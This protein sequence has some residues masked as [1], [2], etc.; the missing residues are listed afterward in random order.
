MTLRN[1]YQANLDYAFLLTR[2]GESTI[3]YDFTGINVDE[4]EPVPVFASSETHVLLAGCRQRV[5]P[6]MVGEGAFAHVYSYTEPEYDESSRSNEARR[7]PTRKGLCASC[8]SSTF[9]MA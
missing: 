4:H 9:L 7:I 3:R 1:H 8:R 6:K 5:R 2:S